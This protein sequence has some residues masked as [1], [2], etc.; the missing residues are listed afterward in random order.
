MTASIGRHLGPR[1]PALPCGTVPAIFEVNDCDDARH[2]VAIIGKQRTYSLGATLD[3]NDWD[4]FINGRDSIVVIDRETL[5]MAASALNAEMGAPRDQY[6][7]RT[8]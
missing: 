3:N 6:T 7:N 1:R 2:A 5:L 8:D 4:Q